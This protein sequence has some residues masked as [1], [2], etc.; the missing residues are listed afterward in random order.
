[1]K[2]SIS[3]VLV[4]VM[5]FAFASCGKKVSENLQLPFGLDDVQAVAIYKA[6][7]CLKVEEAETIQLIIEHL[8]KTQV[9]NTSEIV[10][11][12]ENSTLYEFCFELDDGN[13]Y[14][15]QYY[16]AGVKKGSIDINYGETTYSTTS[17]VGWIWDVLV[18]SD[19][20][21]KIL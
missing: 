10:A 13:K 12:P 14:V 11:S 7:D 1:M 5:V 16:A 21:P 18:P 19:H 9:E 2:K 4:F 8:S 3:L 17:D 6:A 20:H 15:I